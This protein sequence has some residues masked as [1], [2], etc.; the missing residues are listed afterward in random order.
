LPLRGE[1]P[2]DVVAHARLGCAALLAN[3]VISCIDAGRSVSAVR[4]SPMKVGVMRRMLFRP[5]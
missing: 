4:N 2:G 3:E 5:S 1:P